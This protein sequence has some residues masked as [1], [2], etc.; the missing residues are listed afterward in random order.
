MR[1]RCFIINASSPSDEFTEENESNCAGDE[2][3]VIAITPVYSCMTNPNCLALDVYV[4][5]IR[6]KAKSLWVN[7]KTT[8]DVEIKWKVLNSIRENVIY[9]SI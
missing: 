6:M 9:Y 1:K 4:R 3:N 5:Y 2:M 7:P 8:D